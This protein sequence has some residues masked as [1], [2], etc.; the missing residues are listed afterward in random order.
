MITAA[1]PATKCSAGP[2]PVPPAPASPLAVARHTTPTANT[3]TPGRTDRCTAFGGVGRPR[4][5]V[6]TGTAAIVLAGR[7]DAS[8]DVATAKATPMPKAH[9]GRFAASTTCPAACCS[10][11]T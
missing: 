4:S 3:M 7:R 10:V 11:G 6:T 9:H 2:P 1:R 5:A 8:T